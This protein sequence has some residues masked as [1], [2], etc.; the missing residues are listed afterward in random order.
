M[1]PTMADVFATLSWYKHNFVCVLVLLCILSTQFMHTTLRYSREALLNIGKIHHEL[2]YSLL[3]CNFLL[4]LDPTHGRLHAWL[5]ARATQPPLLSLLL[6]NVCSLENKNQNYNPA[7]KEIKEC[8][9]L[10][11]T[12]TWLSDNVPDSALMIHT[13]H[14]LQRPHISLGKDQRRWCLCV[15]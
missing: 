14:A 3:D 12:E 10:I 13:H 9:A 8:C 4:H 2:K 15:C 11:F 6:A 7:W 5:K 1:A